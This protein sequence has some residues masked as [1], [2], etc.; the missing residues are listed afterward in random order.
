MPPEIGLPA[1]A[2]IQTVWLK[3][4]LLLPRIF[5][6]LDFSGMTVAR[7]VSKGTIRG[8]EIQMRLPRSA[9]LSISF[10]AL[11]GVIM[12]VIGTCSYKPNL[13]YKEGAMTSLNSANSPNVTVWY[14]YT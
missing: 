14:D 3:E 8:K 10:P 9:A 12:S 2:A 7:P 1:Q 13:S 11:Y 5:R 6:I 4:T